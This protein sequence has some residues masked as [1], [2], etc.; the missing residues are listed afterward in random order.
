MVTVEAGEGVHDS[1]LFLHCSLYNWLSL[2]WK[3]SIIKSHRRTS[4]MLQWLGILLPVKGMQV[5]F[6][7]WEDPTCRGATKPMCRNYQACMP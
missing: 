2:K 5:Q 7:F 1:L 4:P 6:L 3:V